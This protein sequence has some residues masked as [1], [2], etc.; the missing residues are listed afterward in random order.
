MNVGGLIFQLWELK[1]N[2]AQSRLRYLQ[3]RSKQELEK[4]VLFCCI[5]V[6]YFT[7]LVYLL[8]ET[9]VMKTLNILINYNANKNINIQQAKGS[10]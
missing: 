5:N 4:R 7:F 8:Q 2:A 1:Y 10:V 9:S 3:V 6:L